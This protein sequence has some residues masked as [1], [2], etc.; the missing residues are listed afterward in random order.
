MRE[1]TIKRKKVGFIVQ[2]LSLVKGMKDFKKSISLGRDSR[3]LKDILDENETALKTCKPEK[4][5]ELENEF[6]RLKQS[7][8]KESE[9]KGLE[10]IDSNEIGALVLLTWPKADA[11]LKLNREYNENVA[12]ISNEQVTVE[13]HTELTEKDF[14]KCAEDVM[15]AEAL[16][17]FLKE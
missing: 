15:I 11:W 10:N 9:A 4:Y 17:Y 16:S 5:D 13:V 14:P 1:I 6:R 3:I 2:G 12:R 7:L 8:A